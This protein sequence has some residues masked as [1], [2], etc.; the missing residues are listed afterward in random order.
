ME[1]QNTLKTQTKDYLFP[2]IPRVQLIRNK[3][4]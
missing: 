3:D 2:C 4:I 1:S